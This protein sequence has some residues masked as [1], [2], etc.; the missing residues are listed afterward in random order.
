M[1]CMSICILASKSLPSIRLRPHEAGRSFLLSTSHA[2][3]RQ[4]TLRHHEEL[5]RVKEHK[6]TSRHGKSVSKVIGLLLAICGVYFI[7]DFFYTHLAV[8]KAW[9]WSSLFKGAGLA[10][11]GV[12]LYAK[13]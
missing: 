6:K 1:G 3:D 11:V 4:L 12:Y 9:E 5:N 2:I 8:G 7:G 10:F 13:H